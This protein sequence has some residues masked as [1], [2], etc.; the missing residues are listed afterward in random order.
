VTELDALVVGEK[1]FPGVAIE[2]VNAVR[3]PD[4][5][6][7]VGDGG[8]VVSILFTYFQTFQLPACYELAVRLPFK[9]RQVKDTFHISDTLKQAFISSF[10]HSSKCA[11]YIVSYT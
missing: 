5:A 6:V 9:F 3:C 11:N 4:V 8:H 7:A 2:S 10:M 1:L